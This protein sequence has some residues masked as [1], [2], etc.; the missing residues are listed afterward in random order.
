LWKMTYTYIQSVMIIL[1]FLL[2]SPLLLL[3]TFI[4]F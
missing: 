3:D 1:V 4:C 2:P